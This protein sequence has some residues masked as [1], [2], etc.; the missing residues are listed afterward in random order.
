MNTNKITQISVRALINAPIDKVWRFWTTP[1][2][3]TQWNNA[4]EDWHTP[5][6]ENDF[7][8]CGK[9]LYRMESKDGSNGFDF[10]GVYVTIKSNELIEYILSDGRKVK[11]E[12]LK[13]GNKTNVIEIFEAETINSAELQRHGW[14]AILNN[15]KK[16][17]ESN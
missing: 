11:I 13:N 7:N 8:V 2:H 17:A 15:F 6:A 1:A 12:F 10:D 3:I 9:F 4:S 16:Y 5:H 14:Q